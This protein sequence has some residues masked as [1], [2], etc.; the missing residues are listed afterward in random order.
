MKVMVLGASNNPERYSYRAISMLKDYGH[1]IFAVGNK[2]GEAEGIQIQNDFPEDVKI[3]TLTLYLN[4]NNQRPYFEKILA[5]KPQRVIFNPGT[6]NYEF[7]KELKKVGIETE[8][9]CTLVLLSTGQ[10]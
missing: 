2:K 4:P 6:E 9:A 8:N 3:H 5:L 1:E 10:F 7:Q